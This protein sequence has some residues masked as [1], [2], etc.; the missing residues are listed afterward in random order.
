[1]NKKHVATQYGE[2]LGEEILITD[3]DQ[4]NLDVL[5][6]NLGRVNYGFKLQ[7]PS[8]RKGIRRGIMHDMHFHK[9]INH[10]PLSLN[11]EMMEKIPFDGPKKHNTGP[12]FHRFELDLSDEKVESTFLDC[13]EFGKGTVFVNGF[14]LGRYWSIGPV[15]HLYVPKGLLNKGRNEFIV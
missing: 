2:E 15:G 1:S 13:S 8:Q 14:N 7:A 11:E 9:G 6:E 12:M 4:F 5:V 3:K 10:Y